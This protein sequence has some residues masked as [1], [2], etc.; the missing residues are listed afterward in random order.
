MEH[1]LFSSWGGTVVDRRDPSA[2][3]PATK[4][5]KVPA[6]L[7]PGRALRAFI[8][9]DGLV[10]L[11][12]DV[13]P[14]ELARAYLQAVQEEASCGECFPCRVG[15]RLMLEILSRIAEGKGT[16]E[17]V[18]VLR[19]LAQ[20]V[21]DASKCQIGQTAPVP[22][23]HVLDHFAKELDALIA[24][25]RALPRGE[26]RRKVT[27]PCSDACPA[28]LDIPT[29]VETIKKMR[30]L[31]S[32]AVIR[33]DNAMPGTCGRVCVRP[34]ESHC[35]RANVDEPIAIKPLKRFVSDF[36]S[37]HGVRPPYRRRALAGK[38]AIVGAGPAG[39]A[40]AFNLLRLGHACTLFETLPEPGG[41]A[42]V[43][44]PDYRLPRRV[45]REEV[46]VIESLGGE[47]LYERRLGRD[48]HLDDLLG[49]MGYDAA[50]VAIG[51]HE[52]RLMGVE[53]EEAAYDGFVHG[54]Y[55]LRD[56]NLGRPVFTARK[57][58][59]V[60]GGNVAI[61]VVRCALRVGYD[62]V[63]LVY[64][65]GRTEMPADA[66]EIHDAQEEGIRFH[67]LTN[68]TRLIAENGKIVGV[69]CVRMELGEPDKSGRRRPVVVEGSEFVI[70]CDAVVPAIGQVPDMRWVREQD[71]LTV[72][73]WD[74][75]EA[76]PITMQTKRP[77]VFTAGDCFTGPETLIGAIGGG[78][79]AAIAID[80]LLKGEPVRPDDPQLLDR[81]VHAVG[82]YR[83]DEVIGIVR[84]ITRQAF[85]REEPATRKGHFR[86]V[87]S[88][89]PAAAALAEAR[90]CLRCYRLAVVQV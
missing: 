14:V 35:R 41:M 5:P 7:E 53:G 58:V 31:D 75:I 46:A 88:V 51:A 45:I 77:R 69:Q 19:A 55:W 81:V 1:I 44:I 48:F 2:P 86:E 90:R 17:D 13:H 12:A 73:K 39:L 70:E 32:L 23:L 78:N 47:F 15:T 65:R 37:A 20:D 68:P 67:F 82:T 84:G 22:V 8:G 61:D 38:V 54:V 3:D 10:L 60:G 71:G 85:S 59:C 83:K 28:H 9:W 42:A 49:T 33:Q 25:Q 36:E 24:E 4:A 89:L 76:D 43:G 74:T 50:F 80:K 21:R 16:P 30:Y 29:Y 72:T 6:E 11:D 87:E 64:R 40:A 66:E 56:L 52:S 62:D 18:P 57:L 27:A 63:N 34:C 26:Y 79:R